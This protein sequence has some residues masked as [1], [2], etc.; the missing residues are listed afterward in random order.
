MDRILLEKYRD[1]LRQWGFPPECT[2]KGLTIPRGGQRLCW[3]DGVTLRHAAWM[4]E[5]MIEHLEDNKEWS[6]E[7][8]HLKVIRWIGF[9][10]GVMWMSGFRTVDELR[11][12]VM[13]AK[14][15]CS[16]PCPCPPDGNYGV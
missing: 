5:E 1:L 8:D 15:A 10:Q 16:V 6:G 11:N 9:I 2:G 7:P 13:E 14:K 3:N 4:V 12:D